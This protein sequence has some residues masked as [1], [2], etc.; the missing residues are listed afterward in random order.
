VWSRSSSKQYWRIQSVPQRKHNTSPLQRLLVNATQEN[1]LFT[2]MTSETHKYK[3]HRYWLLKHVVHVVTAGFWSV[4]GLKTK[5]RRDKEDL[6]V[7]TSIQLPNQ[8]RQEEDGG[9]RLCSWSFPVLIQAGGVSAHCW[10]ASF[11]R[12]SLRVMSVSSSAVCSPDRHVLTPHE[13]DRHV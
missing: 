5:M 7:C 11:E 8:R 10:T 2:P 3:M 13:R 4:H 9:K 1:N 6:E 12:A